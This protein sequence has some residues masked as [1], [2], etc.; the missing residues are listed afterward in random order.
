MKIIISGGGT[1]GHVFPAIAIA[2]AIKAIEPKA[3][4]LFVGAEGKIE[5]EK[6]PKAGFPIKGLWISGFHRQ[7]TFRNML[8]PV[9]LM[10]SLIKAR[11][12]VKDFK[13]DVAVGV[14]GYAS[15][16]TLEMATRLG[17]P[18]LIQEQNSYA[19]VTNKLLAKKVAKVCVAYDNMD[20]FFEAEKLVLTGN[21]VREEITQTEGKRAEAITH[22]GLHN[23][24]HTVFIVGGSLGARTLNNAMEANFDAISNHQDVQFVWQCGKLYYEEFKNK[25]TAQLPNVHLTQFVDRMDLAYAAADVVISRAGATSISEL[26]LVKKPVILVPSPNVAEDH[27]TKNAM[28]LV[29]KTA[30]ILVIDK[31]AEEKM[32]TTAIDL[33]NNHNQ[34]LQLSENIE[35]LGKRNAAERIAREVL[36]LIVNG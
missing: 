8:F 23:R 36:K 4:I 10:A 20:R 31:E 28:A 33:L 12:I 26:C 22:F 35:K 7:L 3:D 9:K 29:E 14:G 30:A 6:V 24:K 25:K 34:K 2:N 27:Q 11:S 19:G 15:G 16:P 18:A 1:G 17:V 13:P 32:V 21:P 5:M